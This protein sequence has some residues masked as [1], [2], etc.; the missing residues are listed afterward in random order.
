MITR[1]TRDKVMISYKLAHL[2]LVCRM[3]IELMNGMLSSL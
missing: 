3:A 1:Y 2:D